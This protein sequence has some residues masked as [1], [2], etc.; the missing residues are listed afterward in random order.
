MP[1][2]N[3]QYLASRF[4]RWSRLAKKPT[5]IG[6]IVSMVVSLLSQAMVLL[7]ARPAFAN[8]LATIT[9]TT[10]YDHDDGTCD[11][12]DCTLREAIQYSMEGD[13]IQFASGLEGTMI[14]DPERGELLV[15]HALTINGTSQTGLTISGNGS[16][17]IFD[18]DG[19]A[20]LTISN[21]TLADGYD[22]NYGG[23]AV[24]I[25]YGSFAA[26]NVTFRNNYA[27]DSGGAIY[28][29]DDSL[30][31]TN[32][33]FVGNSASNQGGAIE[34]W[35]YDMNVT[36]SVFTGNNAVYGGAI[37]RDSG[38]IHITGAN[39]LFSNNSAEAG[40]AIEDQGEGGN[41]Y[42][43][44][45]VFKTNSSSGYGGAIDEEWGYEYATS[46]SFIANTSYSDGNG[47]AINVDGDGATFVSSTFI[48]NTAYDGGSGGAID[49]CS[50]TIID[51]SVFQGNSVANGGGVGGAIYQECGATLTIQGTN[52]PSRFEDNSSEYEGGALY[53]DGGNASVTNTVFKGNIA[54]NDPGGAITEYVDFTLASSTFIGNVAENGGE[55]G[56]MYAGGMTT[57]ITS[58][59]F[60][61]N[62]AQDNGTGGALY[63]CTHAYIS[64]SSFENNSANRG[65]AGAIFSSCGGYLQLDRSSF[66]GN[67][68]DFVGA[69]DLDNGESNIANTT[70][71]QNAAYEAGTAVYS[72]AST[73]I[74]NAT[75]AQNAFGGMSGADALYISGGTTHIANSIID[76][77]GGLACNIAESATLASDGHNIVSDASCFLMATGDLNATSSLLDP[78][79]AIDH[80]G[81][82]KSIALLTGSPAINAGDNA[83]CSE[84]DQ[85]GMSR[86]EDGFCDIGAYE[87]N[88]DLAAPVY[89]TGD[90]TVTTLADTVDGACTAELCSLRDAINAAQPDQSIGFAQG[91]T[92]IIMMDGPVGI[93]QNQKIL[94]P[95]KN[96]ISLVGSL[97]SI[98]TVYDPSA[99]VEISGLTF[100]D[101]YASG[102]SNGGAISNEGVLS[103]QDSVIRNCQTNSA[104]GGAIANNG[105]GLNEKNNLFVNNSGDV[106]GAL[107]LQDG[108]TFNSSGSLYTGNYGY[109]GAGAIYHNSGSFTL[110][111]TSFLANA[112]YF[113][114]GALYTNSDAA[115]S[116]SNADF[117]ANA[118]Y[119]DN[120]GAIDQE[121]GALNISNSQFNGNASMDSD[122]GAITLDG[123]TAHITDSTF[124]GNTAYYGNGALS[125]CEDA[126]FENS[127]FIANHGMADNSAGAMYLSCASHYS[128]TGSTFQGNTSYYDGGA[129]YTDTDHAFTIDHTVFDGNATVYG[130]G[131]AITDQGY[132]LTLADD[133]FRDNGNFDGDTAGA[134][135]ENGSNIHI[136]N[137]SFDRN[138]GSPYIDAGALF[139]C[140]DTSLIEQSSF[141]N[142]VAQFSVGGAVHLYCGK[143]DALNSTFA[144][145]IANQGGAFYDSNGTNLQM[146]NST[147]AQN[148][149][150]DDGAALYQDNSGAALTNV[151]FDQNSGFSWLTLNSGFLQLQNTILGGGTSWDCNIVGEST[152]SSLGH[153]ISSS[154]S[155]ELS[156]AG[157]LNETDPM[158][159][160]A[161]LSNN[162]GTVQTIALATH[163]PAIDA[164]N[165]SCPMTDE[166]GT[167]RPQGAACDVG[168][169]EAVGV[170]APVVSSPASSVVTTLND[171]DDG[172]CTEMLC[173]LRDAVLYSSAGSV[174]TFQPG[175]SGKIVLTLG[176]ILISSDLTIQGPGEKQ[177]SITAEDSSRIFDVSYPAVVD[178]SGLTLMNGWSDSD[179]GAAIVNNGSLSLEH[180]ILQGNYADTNGGAIAN[181]G[182][183]LITTD[184]Q[185]I[186]N[187]ANGDGGA[188]YTEG[189]TYTSVSSTYSGNLSDGLG[190][191]AVM[192]N[193]GVVNVTQSVFDTNN[194]PAGGAMYIENADIVTVSSTSFTANTDD[195]NAGG[196]IDHEAGRLVLASSTFDG[197]M[198]YDY[199]NGGAIS[200]NGLSLDVASSTFTGNSDVS[201]GLGGAMYVCEALSIDHSQ[202]TGNTTPWA[203][204]A[205]YED[206]CGYGMSITNS[207]FDA[208]NASE[209]GA[210]EV[211]TVASLSHSTF[212]N[213]VSF[214]GN[215]GAIDQYDFALDVSDSTFTG[216][217][218]LYSSEGGAIDADSS[219]L[220][221]TRSVFDKNSA[222][223]NG[224]GGALLICTDATIDGTTFSEN[225]ATGDAGGAIYQP[226]GTLNV[227][228]SLFQGNTASWG[229]AILSDIGAQTLKVT[230]STLFQNTALGI[231]GAIS[232]GIYTELTNDTLS[233]NTGSSALETWYGS[234]ILE[235]NILS[236]G[237]L[238][239]GYTDGSIYSRG[240]NVETGDTCNLYSD[241]GDHKNTDAK[242]DPRGPLNHGGNTHTIAL[243]TGSPAIDAGFSA[244]CS[245]T[246]QAG[247]SRPQGAQCDMGAYES[248]G[249]VDAPTVA[250]QDITVT[251]LEDLDRGSCTPGDCS[252]REAM[253]A[254]DPHQ[255]I[256]FAQ[257]LTGVLTLAPELGALVV[258]KPLTIVGPG[259]ETIVISA[260]N[261]D[262]HIFAPA[263]G[264]DLILS[265]LTMSNATY[266]GEGGAIYTDENLQV[267]SST[268]RGN[269]ANDWGAAIETF[270]PM[271]SVTSTLF[272]GNYAA[273]NGGAIDAGAMT[274]SIASSTFVGNFAEGNK[275]GAIYDEADG[276]TMNI[277]DSS[278]TANTAI[279]RAGALM[280]DGNDV[281]TITNTSFNANAAENSD[282]GAVYA[283]GSD[284]KM[285]NVSLHGNFSDSAG[286]AILYDTPA[287]MQITGNSDFVGN[288]AA[289]VGGA[290]LGCVFLD[291][292]GATFLGNHTN[293]YQEGAGGGALFQPCGFLRITGYDH[294]TTFRAN[295]SPGMGGALN[296]DDFGAQ[297]YN[298]N[299]IGNVSAYDNGGALSDFDSYG[300][301]VVD[302]SFQKNYSTDNG[303]AVSMNSESDNRFTRVTFTD[304]AAWNQG[305]AF[306][307]YFG[308]LQLDQM[309]FERNVAQMNGGGAFQDNTGFAMTGSYFANN[310]AMAGN[311]G[312]ITTN[313]S[314]STVVS[315][316]FFQN[317]SD[318]GSGVIENEGDIT[319]NNVTLSQ[320]DA[321]SWNDFDQYGS[322]AMGIKN[323]ILADPYTCG[324]GEEPTIT[325]IGHN[326]MVSGSCGFSSSGDTIVADP[327]L[328]VAGPTD[329]GSYNLTQGLAEHSPAIEA[330]DTGTP[331][332]GGMTCSGLDQRGR[333]RPQGDVC[334]IG[335]YELDTLPPNT[336][337]AVTDLASTPDA[338][339]MGLNWTAPSDNGGA[340]VI[341]Y[342]I[343]YRLHG[344]EEW[345]VYNHVPSADT[346]I[347]VE[348]LTPSTRY[349]FEVTPRNYAGLGDPAVIT[350]TTLGENDHTPP[351][352]LS[353]ETA[354][355][356]TAV[357]INWT[358]DE[359]ASAQVQY[360]TTDQYGSETTLTDTDP[361]VTGHS[362]EVSGLNAC[363]LYHFRADSADSYDNATSS[364]DIFVKTT[365]CTEGTLGNV[366]V[367]VTNESGDPVTG[368]MV[369]AACPYEEDSPSAQ[370]LGV[371]DG[372]GVVTESP[373]LL[374][375]C[376]SGDN[377]TFVVSGEGFPE[378][379]LPVASAF[380]RFYTDIDPN[381]ASTYH[382]GSTNVYHLGI[383]TGG[384]WDAHFWN[385]DYD[386]DTLADIP[387]PTTTSTFDTTYN[388]N[389]AKD[390]GEGSPDDSI[391]NDHFFGEFT[392]TITVTDGW[393]NLTTASDDGD[394]VYVD[395]V[396]K[397]DAWYPQGF[398]ELHHRF[399]HLTAGSHTIRIQ[400][401]ED[402]GG[403]GIRFNISP[404]ET[405]E[406]PVLTMITPVTTP[407]VDRIHPTFFYRTTQ[408]GNVV[409][410]GDCTSTTST[411]DPGEQTM[412]LN[413]LADGVHN[414][415]SITVTNPETD[416][417]GT[418]T[419]PAFTVV[420]PASHTISSCEE[421]QNMDAD[422]TSYADRY[423]LTND[424]DCSGVDFHPIGQGWDDDFMGILDGNH[425]KITNL[426]INGG[427]GSNV[428]LIIGMNG[429]QVQDLTLSHGS[430]SG[431]YDVAAIASY[432]YDTDLENVSSDLTIHGHN[433]NYNG[434]LIG[435]VV[436]ADGQSHTW[437]HV[438]ATGAVSGAYDVGG[439][440]G[441]LDI[442]NASTG[443]H[444]EHANATGNVSNEGDSGDY[445][446]GLIGYAEIYGQ[447]DGTTTTLSLVDAH[448][449][450]TVDAG[451]GS[452]VG[453]AIGQMYEEGYGGPVD[454]TISS[455]T[456]N[457]AVSGNNYIGG[458]FG[459]ISAGDGGSNATIEVLHSYATG[460]VTG[461][462]YET[463]G[464]VGHVS[465]YAYSPIEVA[466]TFSD[467]HADGNVVGD[468]N[469]G[470]FLGG[471]DGEGPAVALNNGATGGLIIDR[472]YATGNVMGDIAE[473]SSWY[474]G[475]FVGWLSCQTDIDAPP[476]ACTITRSF[477]SGHVSG[478][479]AIGGFIGYAD[480][481]GTNISDVYA[482]GA[483]GG[484]DLT[485]GF[486]GSL[487]QASSLIQHAYASGA[488]TSYGGSVGGFAGSVN[489]G[490]IQT[491]YATGL[492]TGDTAYG[493]L[494]Q[495]DSVS[496][497]DDY[498]DAS[499]TGRV[500]GNSGDALEGITSVDTSVDGVGSQPGY[501]LNTEN[502]PYTIS[503][504]WNFETVWINHET[505][506]PTLRGLSSEDVTAPVISNIAVTPA[507][508]SATVTWNTDEVASSQ[509]IYAP[510]VNYASSTD[511]SDMDT[512][513][514]DHSVTFTDLAVCSLYHFKVISRDASFN[515]N[516]AQS[517]DA[518]FT[519]TGCAGNANVQSQNANTITTD[520]G[521]S[522][523]HT[524]N[525]STINVQVPANYSATTT[526][527]EVQIKALPSNAAL[528]GIGKPS[529]SVN[530]AA[531]VVFDV[532]ALI[533][534]TTVLDSFDLPV[535]ITY[536]YSDSEVS[537][538][539]LSTLWMYHY[540]DGAWLRLD[541]CSVNTS[542]R[543]VTCST[544]SF[545]TFGLFGQPV[546]SSG[547]GGGA[548]GS[549]GTIP[550][551]GCT[552]SR[553][554]NYN[555]RATNMSFL[556]Q[557]VYP[558]ATTTAPV[559][560]APVAT[561]TP[562]VVSTPVVTPVNQL[563]CTATF[564]LKH[565]VKFGSKNDPND[566][567]LLE[568][569][570]NT[571]EGTSL[572]IDG[573]YSKAGFAAV[574]K[575]QEKYASEILTPW[576]LKK[577]TGY[578]FTT[579]LKKMNQ[580]REKICAA[581]TVSSTAGASATPSVTTSLPFTFT[582]D[583]KVGSKGEDVRQLQIFLNAHGFL[584]A[585]SGAGS[586]GKEATTFGTATKKALSA[587]QKAHGL[588]VDGQFAGK[589][590]ESVGSSL[591]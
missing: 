420:P 489:N 218:A 213:N 131:G 495:Y 252:L 297:V 466:V 263:P 287:Y 294:P 404:M 304:N 332:T 103:L 115:V 70:F 369:K 231:G 256:G 43:Q 487:N 329:H 71:F 76:E 224:D 127:S 311:G 253:N 108:S 533:D 364:A 197:N 204:G 83:L 567:K 156:H 46:T 124:L 348:Y 462:A 223:A 309:T 15:D 372:S 30:T 229:G 568:K 162:G 387:F 214:D 540:H 531:S 198:T 174:I 98:L 212:T 176:Q 317:M 485:G 23:G 268:F 545:S 241:H 222:P 408:G 421:L 136:I 492:M 126:S 62:S 288:I 29:D 457:G 497:A 563:S 312:A 314:G 35:G 570:L 438:L 135:Y 558:G 128:V 379:V 416:L 170:E 86:S 547:G 534:S 573:I 399:V 424:I 243:L 27:E 565:P 460:D 512:R 260:N 357:T 511:E 463:G 427:E 529:S 173:S 518:T 189:D 132:N 146:Q 186:G 68:A 521:G 264:G 566:V 505:L 548:S 34:M 353:V 464:F 524:A 67:S 216:N 42:M 203:G 513:V 53:L 63:L 72:N 234:T 143:L 471:T 555:P 428:A 254:A 14:L 580:I 134:V 582:H 93:G 454:M 349:D 289:N 188:V 337:A 244:S 109:E 351:V 536:H 305:G 347:D 279:Y 247:T 90:L 591:R 11:V 178:L 388:D 491:S 479:N 160:S 458:F 105:E 472:S 373:L 448:G 556:G 59:T 118:V 9:V 44:D 185:F 361:R 355:T 262:Q 341:D 447:A 552:D 414:N 473:D 542:A 335:A 316:T 443:F 583:L 54:K 25:N 475:G 321:A 494:G 382:S 377:M 7:P 250:T 386:G 56:A 551:Y 239:C 525:G 315:T 503:P 285:T 152:L 333:V 149:A 91:L 180:M 412:V 89:P 429:A 520:V 578:V 207:T 506:L 360:G 446:G 211:G 117:T 425:H 141:T 199:G 334:D 319:L 47:G 77:A 169:F 306:N 194:A 138:V 208:N 31:L 576:G 41:L 437:S 225:T 370:D 554:T 510:N 557:C 380:D 436:F 292:D 474:A 112:A 451:S 402:E 201:G 233:Q 523:S 2:H 435:Y 440:I 344:A 299:F 498:F 142:N 278:F 206:D 359:A 151:T 391:Q 450:G 80:G 184:V 265:G 179:A 383:S 569:Y 158:F 133:T 271:L 581:Q 530:S 123:S 139:I 240:H 209:G 535:T 356:D 113:S 538:L 516:R 273:S 345:I 122:D 322:S 3:T 61:Y 32:T 415:C 48:G 326:L 164:G 590:R 58:S 39:S 418:L 423:T 100:A 375:A 588:K 87:S 17:R 522:V 275:G 550:V 181:Y 205:I 255:T 468:T 528:A 283:D 584:V 363:T 65:T 352:I 187:H 324:L 6:T 270:G 182:T 467:D 69:V 258:D 496:L 165:G 385:S 310:I 456:A 366:K 295:S 476:Y 171:S 1:S 500:A 346:N 266:E 431:G 177:L 395:D 398:S 490:T 259:Q 417:S 478:N 367:I 298:T 150:N 571:Y 219:Q 514:T 445:L 82:G 493:F 481:N 8:P 251:T 102:D 116:I 232:T 515:W 261:N 227:T 579:S 145:N 130:N 378:Q 296:T 267:S 172:S 215:G 397:I 480:N 410:N 433:A 94:G 585:K 401:F 368:A 432:A 277:S 5:A 517:D 22:N 407:L 336:P 574:V 242:L 95:G 358:T 302:S 4:A 155:C 192:V 280:S 235:N 50:P 575:W 38:D 459:G 104:S 37:Y 320:N 318:A 553:A 21:M 293:I 125:A 88:S 455:S 148:G 24:Y 121:G 339:F 441:Y 308:N 220:T 107:F 564:N 74:R 284:M 587:F 449:R 257:G 465:S 85:R 114:A 546:R 340:V 202:F 403:A 488:V 79:G 330:G 301:L 66:V 282:G 144:G 75:F 163:S 411:I 509:V 338:E 501:F 230:N 470:G 561:S 532:T 236:N 78:R 483:V 374:P 389:L 539:D 562:V 272:S 502:S 362:V 96:A 249:A 541:S 508:H 300:L 291:I 183:S 384:S 331:D 84:T 303:G 469:V 276:G 147:L 18:V 45:T 281:T 140:N 106:G 290:I 589:T 153:N 442:E 81:I 196:A 52:L 560:Y 167:T 499:T 190:G 461:H 444:I 226:C 40:G 191:G 238:N 110:D 221:I 99:S 477:A 120:G 390:W 507:T 559:V 350:D 422:E 154:P 161:G 119:D 10:L 526:S 237:A 543:T 577:G 354:A 57:N 307:H 111:G 549:S 12:S 159:S 537:G 269:Y 482:S 409:F 430:V 343:R 245:L 92:G 16:N 434:G 248:T 484:S 26:S 394:R 405:P 175:L 55:G 33:T 200:A 572:P 419:I 274:Q 73:T 396:E 544:P 246:D 527:I 193:A 413:K 228:N 137:T 452:D 51:G 97:S 376:T 327:K 486:V 342:R 400:M 19:G 392:K 365:G 217:T 64:D 393:Y 586:K 60:S 439:L 381:N 157:D 168:A 129:I 286:G 504:A 328:D 519:T 13:T 371:T 453:G 426:T 210:I 36:D 195:S 323:S 313:G 28:N 325:S 406:A 166:I 49:V 20:I 101:G